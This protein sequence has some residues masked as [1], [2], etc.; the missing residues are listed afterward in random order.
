MKCKK[1]FRSTNIDGCAQ[2]SANEMEHKLEKPAGGTLKYS[3][4]VGIP[5]R[6]GGSAA[7]SGIVMVIEGSGDNSGTGISRIVVVIEDN[8][9]NVSSG[10]EE[11][12]MRGGGG[13]VFNRRRAARQ[14]LSPSNDRTTSIAKREVLLE[15]MAKERRE[16]G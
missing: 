9:A 13:G 5:C 3:K 8:G 12:V 4:E 1:S 15:A 14:A 6:E 10:R 16:M 7:I 11:M 2:G